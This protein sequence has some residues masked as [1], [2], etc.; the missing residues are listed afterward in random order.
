MFKRINN[1]K[2]KLLRRKYLMSQLFCD[3]LPALRWVYK[4]Y[5]DLYLRRLYGILLRRNKSY[6]KF[7]RWMQ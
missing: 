2:E 6:S 5:E 7:N 4:E 3:M 1:Q